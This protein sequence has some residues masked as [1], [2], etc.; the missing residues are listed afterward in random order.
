MDL[1]CSYFSN[2]EHKT[3][4]GDEMEGKKHHIEQK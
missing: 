4:C 1:S 2:D 3:F